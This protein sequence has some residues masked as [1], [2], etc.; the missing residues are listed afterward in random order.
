LAIA[1]GRRAVALTLMKAHGEPLAEAEEGVRRGGMFRERG[2]HDK[3]LDDFTIAIR[4]A[5]MQAGLYVERA[6]SH[7]KLGRLQ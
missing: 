5:P 7:E 6:Q 1:H 3:V 4:N 2:A